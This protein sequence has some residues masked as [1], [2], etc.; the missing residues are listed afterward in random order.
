MEKRT[1]GKLLRV[2]G[3]CGLCLCALLAVKWLVL[4][5]AVPRL[6]LLEE[7]DCFGGGEPVVVCRMTNLSTKFVYHGTE[8]WVE[9]WNEDTS[10]WGEYL[11]EGREVNFTLPLMALAPLGS[12][13]VEYPAYYFAEHFAVGRYRV[14]QTVRCGAFRDWRGG[15]E[16][17]LYCEFTVTA[18]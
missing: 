18:P 10:A 16:V 2:W 15:E 3:V 14:A 5:D 8:F 17:T 7:I 1:K 13:T 12:K 9:R 6:R 4:D 11:E